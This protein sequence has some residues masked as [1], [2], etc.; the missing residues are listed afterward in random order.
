[1]SAVAR[2][3]FVWYEMMAS[4]PSGAEAF[5]TKLIGWTTKAGSIPDMPYTEWMNGETP[6]GGLMPLPDEAKQSGAPPHWL[7]YVTVPSV[8]DTRQQAEGLG[9]KTLMGPMDIETVGRIAVL[10]DPQGAVFAIYTP[11]GDAPGHEGQ[12]AVGEFSWH[13]LWTSDF[14]AAFDFYSAL[15]GWVKGERMEVEPGAVYQMYGRAADQ[16]LGG[17][18]NKPPEMPGPPASWLLYITVPDVTTAI[19]TVKQLG[20]QV[21]HGPEE[22]P[23]GDV[24][25]QC[26]DSQGAAFALHSR[27]PSA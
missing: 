22:V 2:G 5:Y 11:A 16:P 10:Q 14:E 8:D 4:D 17:M 6:V 21:W 1:M 24:V 12:P 25:A 7:A 3:R 18:M 15:F 13:E 9:A 23:G 19:D 27:K 26:M 20:G